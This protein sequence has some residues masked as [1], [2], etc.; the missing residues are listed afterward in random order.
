MSEAL[1]EQQMAFAAH[2]RDP[3]NNAAPD[4]IEDRRMAIYRDLVFNGLQGLLAS[5]FPVI[6]RMLGDAPWR[7]LVR[8]FLATHRART[9]LFTEVGSEF[10]A[11]LPGFLQ[12]HAPTTTTDDAPTWM[13][14]FA[15]LTWLPELAHYEYAELAL[16]I[17]DAALPAHD[18]TADVL[19]GIPVASP[20]AWPLAYAWPVHRIGPDF[21]PDAPPAQP[22][23]LLLRRDAG[24]DV[25][26]STL[27][28]LAYR[29]LQ[30]IEDNA[31]VTG[32]ALL[33]A[34]AREAAAPDPDAFLRDG[35]DALGQLRADGVLL[36]TVPRC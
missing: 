34:L 30:L 8:A 16:S 26:F 9:P 29:L 21:R 36:G 4:G 35:A 12:T 11:W 31:T 5:N 18:P 10:V 20:F 28:P 19:D 23:L 1:R 25:Q 17:S 7:A 2:L 14:S 3:A 32:R 24:G 13:P 33:Q 22:T 27:S 15:G 6:R